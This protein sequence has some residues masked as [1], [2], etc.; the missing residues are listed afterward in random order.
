MAITK[1][2]ILCRHS[3]F[4]ITC[5]NRNESH[6]PK[7]HIN[8]SL[9]NRQFAYF[10][11]NAYNNHCQAQVNLLLFNGFPPRSIRIPDTL[12][13]G[14]IFLFFFFFFGATFR[15]LETGKKRNRFGFPFQIET[16]NIIVVYVNVV[17]ANKW[18]QPP[19]KA[20]P[21]IP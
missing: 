12:S 15:G 5:D 20:I 13:F 2:E 18:Q 6:E 21:K 1:I 9:T 16:H 4:P 17:N 11:K 7:S 19:N 14:S 10:N 8:S 3:D